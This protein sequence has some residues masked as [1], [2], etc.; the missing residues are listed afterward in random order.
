MVMQ[1]QL[2]LITQP[3]SLL[4]QAHY[5]IM[6]EHYQFN[7]VE[8][9]QILIHFNQCLDEYIYSHETETNPK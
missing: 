3:H 6:L 1:S 8:N 2:S 7:Q 4:H 9:G 5:C